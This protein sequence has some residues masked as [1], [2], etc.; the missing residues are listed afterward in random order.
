[1]KFVFTI[2]LCLIFSFISYCQSDNL[3][4]LKAQWVDFNE[5]GD[6]NFRVYF[7]FYKDSIIK[8]IKLDDNDTVLY[9][10]KESGNYDF[11]LIE[12]RFKDSIADYYFY[13]QELR[14]NND[15]NGVL[16]F[17][18]AN[19]DL[20]FATYKFK[21]GE[22]SISKIF[23]PSNKKPI[24]GFNTKGVVNKQEFK[25]YDYL[26]GTFWS[27]SSEDQCIEIKS[28]KIIVEHSLSDLEKRESQYKI[29]NDSI[30]ILDEDLNIQ[31]TLN[32]Q[33]LKNGI[34]VLKTE[35]YRFYDGCSYEKV[36]SLSV[37]KINFN[38][39][40]NKRKLEEKNYF[41]NLSNVLNRANYK[42]FTIG[43]YQIKYSKDVKLDW[44][45]ALTLGI[46]F[47]Q[48]IIQNWRLPSIEELKEIYNSKKILGI[49]NG[50]FW[51]STSFS[52]AGFIEYLDFS[53]GNINSE[54]AGSRFFMLISNNNNKES[55]PQCPPSDMRI[56]DKQIQGTA[57]KYQA[58][59]GHYYYQVILWVNLTQLQ[60]KY[61]KT[62]KYSASGA[63]SLGEVKK[64]IG[65]KM[66]INGVIEN[67]KFSVM[68]ELKCIVNNQFVFGTIYFR[69]LKM[70]N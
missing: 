63:R 67:T 38:N 32:I 33:K 55:I 45:N 9:R 54:S 64:S 60:K 14:N 52:T 15:Y 41:T 22:D 11:S 51:S 59:D 48:K 39:Y 50:E 30:K 40:I 12:N 26:I 1:M 70:I 10:S 6:V 44:S 23:Y 57:R 66:I 47:D 27:C 35:G 69:D 37:A 34:T 53:N 49:N 18:S 56:L 13:H 24:K 25:K 65:E 58:K 28:N 46:N 3:I 21:Y 7:D 29:E 62:L 61:Y 17:F 8:N 36:K 20:P 31:K 68:P 4:I 5:E 43:N 2:L 16:N 42:Y 19:M